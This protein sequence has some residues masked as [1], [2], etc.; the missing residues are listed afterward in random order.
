[1]ALTMV[2]ERRN[3]PFSGRPSTSSGMVCIRSPLATADMVRVTWVVGHSRSSIRVL[4]DISMSP[5]APLD[6]PKRTRV[7]VLPSRPT[8]SPTRSSCWAM[9]WLAA[10]ISL[11]VSATRPA[12]PL[13]WLGRRAEKSP[14]RIACRA[15]SSRLRSIDEPSAPMAGTGWSARAMLS[16]RCGP[17]PGGPAG[18]SGSW[19]SRVSSTA[20]SVDFI[21]PPTEAI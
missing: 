15:S 3:S 18:E 21:G 11:K 6:R 20:L 9:R 10:T 12:R 14:A 4:T 16:K 19:T 5:Q 13:S 7:L 2:A 8:T 1:M 17:V